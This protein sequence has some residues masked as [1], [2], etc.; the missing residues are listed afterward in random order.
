MNPVLIVGISLLVV[1]AYFIWREF[2]P[3]AKL[4]FSGAR[5]RKPKEVRKILNERIFLPK[6]VG[7]EVKQ[8]PI[9]GKCY[10]CGKNTTMPYK[11]KFCSG[12]YCDKHR[13]PEA[14]ECEGLKKLKR[15]QNK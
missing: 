8:A 1:L 5:K 2:Q 6:E 12:L 3:S 7:G 4:P 10:M 9:T 15:E 14:H 13:L 11:C